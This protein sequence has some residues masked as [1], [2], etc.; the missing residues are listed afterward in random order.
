MSKNKNRGF[1]AIELV[2]A[3][4]IISIL[5]GAII[6]HS[7]FK[8]RNKA[9]VAY[10]T[11]ENCFAKGKFDYAI[12]SY[13]PHLLYDDK[14]EKYLLSSCGM[15]NSERYFDNGYFTK[16]YTVVGDKTLELRFEINGVKFDLNDD[17]INGK[18][19]EK[20]YYPSTIMLGV[21][22]HGNYEVK[23]NYKYL[24]NGYYHTGFVCSD[25]NSENP[26]VVISSRLTDKCL[27]INTKN[28]EME[29]K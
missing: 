29:I 3:V 19:V 26:V 7:N 24:E 22:V 9:L 23:L 27:Y 1:T 17:K 15:T 6:V 21:S 8:S 20:N 5:A 28:N 16:D 10:K 11:L 4:V 25:E 13:N 2:I 18:T 12:D 14:T